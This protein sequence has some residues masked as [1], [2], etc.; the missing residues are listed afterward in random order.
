MKR[1]LA[2]IMIAFML[3]S[4]FGCEIVPNNND[5]NGT[6][7]DAS[8]DNG[9]ENTSGSENQEETKDWYHSEPWNGLNLR[10]FDSYD[11]LMAAWKIIEENKGEKPASYYILPDYVGENYS[12]VYKIKT[13]TSCGADMSK[14]TS[15]SSSVQLYLH[16]TSRSMCEHNSPEDMSYYAHGVTLHRTDPDMEKYAYTEDLLMVQIL[17][18]TKEYVAIEDRSLLRAEKTNTFATT[19]R[20]NI[21]I[22]DQP[23][24]YDIFYGDTR[25]VRLTSCIELDDEVIN[26]ILNNLCGLYDLQ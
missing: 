18:M 3:L 8:S 5:D 10:A 17:T 9:E 21:W 22:F 14:Q 16:G 25:I 1:L 12:V 15:T 4:M 20:P 7:G 6:E 19:P 23:I 24:K 2:G 13:Y 11:T 26:L